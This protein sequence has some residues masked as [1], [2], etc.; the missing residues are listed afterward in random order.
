MHAALPWQVALALD[1][2]VELTVLAVSGATVADVRDEQAS[3]VPEGSDLVVIDVGSNDVTHLTRAADFRA[4]Y[5]DVLD[6][7]PAGTPVVVL[8]VPDMGSITRLPQP[9]R[10]IAGVRGGTL[11][12][13][14]ARLARERDLP[15]V[16]IAGETGPAFRRDPGR[17]FAADAYHPNDAGYG[18]WADAVVPVLRRAV[19][20]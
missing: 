2:P 8:G 18:L 12:R 9:L 13:E 10:F 6:A 19:D 11:D 17:Y 7:L 15:Y 20:R 16:D 14:V 3:Q 1:R 4:R 5:I